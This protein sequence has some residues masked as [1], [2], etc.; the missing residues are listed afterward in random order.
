[1]NAVGTGNNPHNFGIV[2]DAAHSW[3]SKGSIPHFNIGQ[4]IQR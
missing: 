2:V 1:M 3:H 4:K